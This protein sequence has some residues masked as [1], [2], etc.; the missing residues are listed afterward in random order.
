MKIPLIRT[1]MALHKALFTLAGERL[2]WRAGKHEFLLLHNKGRKT[3]ND[4]TTPLSFFRDGEDY[5]VVASNWGQSDHPQWFL[6]LVDHPQTVI[7]VDAEEIPVAACRAWGNVREGLWELVT[8]E[9]PQYRRYQA[10]VSRQIPVVILRPTISLH[11]IEMNKE[12]S[13]N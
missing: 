1:F 2:G 7:E 10:G 11:P 3:G 9:N 6:N 12:Y 5:I 8:T 13:E 4:Y